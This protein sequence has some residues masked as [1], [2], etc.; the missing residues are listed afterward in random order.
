MNT[1]HKALAAV[2]LCA[3]AAPAVSQELYGTLKKVRDSKVFTIGHREASFPFAFYDDQK[4]P[5][6]GLIASQRSGA[7]RA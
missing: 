3:L 6:E 2:A 1:F 5:T 7:G 4:K